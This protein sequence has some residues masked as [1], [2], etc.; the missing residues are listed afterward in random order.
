M[1]TILLIF[2]SAFFASAVWANDEHVVKQYCSPKKFAALDERYALKTNE[3]KYYPGSTELGICQDISNK[4]VSK[5][6]TLGDRSSFDNRFKYNWEERILYTQFKDKCKALS[7]ATTPDNNALIS[8]MAEFD[9]RFKEQDVDILKCESIAHVLNRAKVTWEKPPK[10]EEKEFKQLGI[11]CTSSGIETLDFAACVDFAESFE[12]FEAVQNIGYQGQQLIY[13]EKMATE[14]AKVA[15]E[16]DAAKGALKATKNSM[17]NQQ[18][19]YNQRAAVDTAK[20]AMLY[21][22]FKEFPT[23]DIITVYCKNFKFK[24]FG[25]QECYDNV[26]GSDARFEVLQNQNMRDK[27]QAKLIQVAASAGQNLIVAGLMGKRASDIDKALAKVDNFQPIDP[28]TVSED[29]FLTSFCKQNPGAEKCLTGG[30]DRSIDGISDNVITFGDGATGTAYENPYNSLTPTSPT[31]S[32]SKSS[33]NGPTKIGSV[34]ASAAQDN[35]IEGSTGATVKAGGTGGAGSSGGGAASG[36]SAGGG[37]AGGAAG[38]AQAQADARIPTKAPSY[39]G[40]SGG[41]SVL[42]GFGINKAKTAAKDEGNPFGKLFDK[43]GAKSNLVNLPGE[44]GIASTK[45]GDKS[46]DLFKMIS[47]RYSSVKA[48]KRLLEYEL[49]K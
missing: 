5:F 46:E 15:E 1:K 19:M 31:S 20:L 3:K 40:G 37:A 30:L 2:S 49:A 45:V 43:D 7:D 44:R 21:S 25:A 47:N 33:D 38:Q 10:N 8:L 12:N 42:G 36:G 34:L 28:F 22:K 35:S 41:L 17:E 32:D 29:E 39:G 23:S 24:T 14:Q 11:K 27:M 6:Y 9:K 4:Q 18:D 13:Q 16:K 26:I 48:D